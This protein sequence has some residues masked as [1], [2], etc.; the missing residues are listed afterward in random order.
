MLKRDII[1]ELKKIYS[2]LDG[3]KITWYMEGIYYTY[4]NVQLANSELVEVIF[5]GLNNVV[6][7][8]PSDGL[9]ELP[10]KTNEP[11]GK[12]KDG[13]PCYRNSKEVCICELPFS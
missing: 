3:A 1:P 13:S 2:G 9:I 10:E 12:H 5:N 8:S 4:A 11:T 7:L 6:E